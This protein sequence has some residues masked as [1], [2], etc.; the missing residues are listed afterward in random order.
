[1]STMLYAYQKF[2]MT[3]DTLSPLTVLSLLSVML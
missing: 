2:L 1:M 3:L